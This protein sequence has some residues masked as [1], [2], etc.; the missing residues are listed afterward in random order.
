MFVLP[1]ESDLG[2]KGREHTRLTRVDHRVFWPRKLKGYICKRNKEEPKVILG[3]FLG[4]KMEKTVDDRISV[5]QW[6]SQIYLPNIEFQ[7]FVTKQ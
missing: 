5:A 2:S 7:S 3:L 4:K 6:V 1:M